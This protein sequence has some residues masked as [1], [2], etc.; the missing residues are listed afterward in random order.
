MNVFS[1]NS[2]YPPGLSDSPP[3]TPWNEPY[4]QDPIEVDVE[5]SVV[6]RKRT[7][8]STTDYDRDE[9]EE[10]E[11]DEDGYVTRFGGT[12]I[13]YDN[14]D[15]ENEYNNQHYSPM[16]LI[17]ILKAETERNLREH[18]ECVGAKDGT[19]QNIID[20]CDNWIAEDEIFDII[21]N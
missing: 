21:E 4:D 12:E 3:G 11:R 9:W 7:T 14:V 16:E 6:L 20:E 19:W 5:Y 17:R 8:I 10:C 13:S 15:V 18:P 2:N 1:G